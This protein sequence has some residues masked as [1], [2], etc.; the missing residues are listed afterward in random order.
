MIYA[1]EGGYSKDYVPFC[2]LAVI[3]KLSGKECA[4]TDAYGAVERVTD[5]YLP[6]VN[7]W[8]YQECQLH[9]Q[10]LVDEVAA[11]HNIPLSS[12]EAVM[13]QDECALT[14]ISSILKTMDSARQDAILKK[15]KEALLASTSASI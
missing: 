4:A 13:Q 1:H 8:G 10:T 11:I 9:Q 6:E 12:D 15:V 3:E 2:A 5:P 7:N 14:T